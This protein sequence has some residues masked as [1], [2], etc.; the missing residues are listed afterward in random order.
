MGH[1]ATLQL[2]D[3]LADRIQVLL[4]LTADGGYVAVRVR[5]RLA[6]IAEERERVQAELMD[7][8]PSLLA[9]PPP[10]GTRSICSTTRSSSTDRRQ[11]E[12]V[13]NSTRSFSNGST[14]MRAA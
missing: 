14:S 13:A 4:D 12:Y 11:T 6:S 7:V 5:E 1:Y 10:F 2:P 8:K 3:A 9:G